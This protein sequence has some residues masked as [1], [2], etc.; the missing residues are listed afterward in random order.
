VWSRD[1][2]AIAYTFE[3]A[4]VSLRL[5]KAT[6]R[7]K[8]KTLFIPKDVLGEIFANSWTPD[9]KQI[10]C[11]MVRPAG[12]NAGQGSDLVLVPAAGGD[13]AP[14][15]ASASSGQ[16]SPDG[17]WVAYASNESGAWEIYVTSFPDAGGKWQVSHGGGNEPRWRGDSQEIFYVG[18]TGLLMAVPVDTK[19]TFSTGPHASLFQTYRRAPLASTDL[20]TYD[21]SKDGKRF[22]VNRHVKPDH[23][24][25]LTIVLHATANPPK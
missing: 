15:L 24:M 21:V 13:P 25:P 18:P 9:D 6:G 8:E 3:G 5:K 2:N 20:F 23:V 19:S 11:T 17:K 22:L 1:G 7:E 12:A 14:F 16:I 4:P 10:L